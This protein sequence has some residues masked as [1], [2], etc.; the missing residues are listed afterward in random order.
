MTAPPFL[1][2]SALPAPA[3]STRNVWPQSARSVQILPEDRLTQLTFGGAI[4]VARKLFRDV[5]KIAIPH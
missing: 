2:P 5:I 3:S 4:N 1:W